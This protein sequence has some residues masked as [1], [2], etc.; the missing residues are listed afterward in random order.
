MLDN[1]MQTSIG[2]ERPDAPD[3]AALVEELESELAEHY[4]VESRHGYSVQKLIAQ[5][6][7]FF[8]LRCDDRPAGCGGIQFVGSEYGELKRMFVR[9]EFRG[10]G[11]SKII[12]EHLIAV[13]RERGVALVRLETG[14]HQHAAIAL[15]EGS[16]FYQIPPFGPYREDPVSRC[17]EK[18]LEPDERAG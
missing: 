16:G 5:G 8:V 4:P 7:L 13:A 9:P 10:R 2:R 6:V 3:A 14:I 1:V 11:L 18:R 15:Y 17:Y 12:L